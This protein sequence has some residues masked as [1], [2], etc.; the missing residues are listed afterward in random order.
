MLGV[1][2]V[3]VKQSNRS[4]FD[5][6]EILRLKQIAFSLRISLRESHISVIARV[7]DVELGE[8]GHRRRVAIEDDVV[9]CHSVDDVVVVG[10]AQRAGRTFRAD[11]DVAQSHILH[12]GITHA[13]GLGKEF[14]PP[15]AAGILDVDILHEDVAVAA[16]V[17]LGVGILGL[18]ADGAAAVEHNSIENLHVALLLLCAVTHL[19]RAAIAP[20]NAVVE[21]HVIELLGHS[22]PVFEELLTHPCLC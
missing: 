22:G 17:D 5:F 15:F 3:G 10:A 9:E 2:I 14:E 21:G 12:R 18:D 13:G 7:C 1:E 6:I 4:V 20:R 19:E 8:R 16:D 11:V